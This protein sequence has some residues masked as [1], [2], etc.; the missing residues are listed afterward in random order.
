MY[1]IYEI[2]ND[3]EWYRR[4]CLDKGLSNL[5]N[6]HMH[7]TNLKTCVVN[8]QKWNYQSTSTYENV[9]SKNIRDKMKDF[10]KIEY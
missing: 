7:V 8:K 5:V 6:I 10:G 2:W 4:E 3:Y 1:Y 9:Y